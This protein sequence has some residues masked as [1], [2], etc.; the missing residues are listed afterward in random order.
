MKLME[1]FQ[2]AG[3]KRIC[4]SLLGNLFIGFGVAIFKLS[5]MGNDSFN[6]MNI[7]CRMLCDGSCALVCFPC[8][9]A[10]RSG[11]TPVRVRVWSRDCIFQ[12]KRLGAAA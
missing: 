7:W 6:G 3:M 8:R 4:M 10:H 11:N 2:K 1:Y 5:A 12:Q 9:R